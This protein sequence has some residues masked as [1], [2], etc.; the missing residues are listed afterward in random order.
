MLWQR[1]AVPACTSKCTHLRSLLQCRSCSHAALPVYNARPRSV[2][3]RELHI[4]PGRGLVRQAAAALG[5]DDPGRLVAHGRV[6]HKASVLQL[7]EEAASKLPEDLRALVHVRAGPMQQQGQQGGTQLGGADQGQREQEGE[8]E[9][10]ATVMDAPPG[11]GDSTGA[12]VA[13]Y[14]TLVASVEGEAAAVAAAGDAAVCEVKIRE[15]L[16]YSTLPPDAAG[17]GSS[18][19]DAAAA[20][21][22]GAGLGAG[23]T[24]GESGSGTDGAAPLNLRASWVVGYPV[25][26][27]VLFT[28]CRATMAEVRHSAPPG[29]GALGCGALG[30][31]FYSESSCTIP[32]CNTKN[33]VYGAVQVMLVLTPGLATVSPSTTFRRGPQAVAASSL[34]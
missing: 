5:L 12:D 33:V 4:T 26:G 11:S 32:K 10:D 13:S 6:G 3:V 22:L 9:G 27:P 28:R 20:A 18:G 14:A 16:M 15:P 19:R 17:A 8:R 30:I 24:V 29:V 34:P 31:H 21:G 2:P 25:Y 1:Q 7:T 23:G